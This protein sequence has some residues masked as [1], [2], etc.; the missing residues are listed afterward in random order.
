[1]SNTQINEPKEDLYAIWNEEDSSE[2]KS[3]RA[4]I[5]VAVLIHAILLILTFP[6]FST[7]EVE[8]PKKKK[9]IM[10]KTVRFKPKPPQR[11]PTP[12]KKRVKPIA[13]PAPDPDVIEYVSDEELMAPEI[14]IDIGT[15]FDDIPEPPPMPQ[16]KTFYLSGEVDPPV[17]VHYVDPLYTELARRSRTHGTVILQAIIDTQGQVTEVKVLKPLTMGLTEEAIKAVKQ[18][19]YDPSTK[20]GK[21]VNVQL[22]VT[23]RFQLQ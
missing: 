22:S 18:W 8:E 14:P 11:E 3:L 5:T 15:I 2:K 23:I 7:P 20:D 19:R 12:P 16:E 6:A 10:I 4:S 1:M 13:V 17:R 21:P 9:I